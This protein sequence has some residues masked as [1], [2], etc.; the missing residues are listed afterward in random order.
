MRRI[1]RR[2]AD[3]KLAHVRRIAGENLLLIQSFRQDSHV[4]AA[5]LE[6]CE[7]VRALVAQDVGHLCR[8]NEPAGFQLQ[9]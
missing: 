2:D 8:Q 9:L 7:M 4:P 3:T 6:L 5:K 1:D